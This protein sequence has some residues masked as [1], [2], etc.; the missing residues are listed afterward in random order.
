MPRKLKPK[1][2]DDKAHNSFSGPDTEESYVGDVGAR[3]RD[4]QWTD[5][6]EKN[7]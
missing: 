1:L 3:M 7:L 4:I 5:T 6:E 2:L